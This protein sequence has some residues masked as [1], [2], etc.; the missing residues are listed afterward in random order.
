ML[1]AAP[2][3]AKVPASFWQLLMQY[4]LF[5]V[6]QW[7]QQVSRSDPSPGHGGGLEDR[8][9]QELCVAACSAANFAVRSSV[10]EPSTNS[11]LTSALFTS[12]A[13]D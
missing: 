1:L 6:P 13:T 3:L 4:I 2:R 7:R 10:Q 8:C 12:A 11:D 9:W 5:L